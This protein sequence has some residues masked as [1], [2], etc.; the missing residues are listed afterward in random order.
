MLKRL[1][2]LLLLLLSC[3]AG[4]SEPELLEPEKAFRFSARLLDASQVE[5][6]YE[7]APGYYM[8][9]DKF[10][11]VA[12]SPSIT[13]DASQL[14]PGKIKKD[15]YFGEMQTYRG[16]QRFVLPVKGLVAPAAGFTLKAESQGCADIG[17]CYPPLEQTAALVQRAVG[18]CADRRIVQR[19][20]LGAHRELLRLRPAAG[21]H[22]MRVS[23]DTH[24]VG[25]PCAAR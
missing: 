13:V 11:F 21:V 18:R 16:E 25:H 1:I 4:A 19:R 6:R 7:I 2:P 12:N 24:P 22:A 3:G 10:K 5:V 23:D 8:Y 20:I 14:P 17:V 15:D 9:R